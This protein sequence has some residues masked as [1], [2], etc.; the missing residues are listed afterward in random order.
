MHKYE[1][2]YIRPQPHMLLTECISRPVCCRHFSWSSSSRWVFV[3]VGCVMGFSTED[4]EAAHP[5]LMLKDFSS[6][7]LHSSAECFSAE[8]IHLKMNQQ[9]SKAAFTLDFIVRYSFEWSA[10]VAG[11]WTTGGS[12]KRMQTCVGKKKKVGCGS[13]GVMWHHPAKCCIGQSGT[14]KCT[15]FAH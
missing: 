12:Y 3:T 2:Y 11:T 6:C 7:P 1:Y 5:E 15:F 8:R 4:I 9:C 10:Y 14:C 13:A